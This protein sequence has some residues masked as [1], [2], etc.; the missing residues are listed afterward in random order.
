M[1]VSND[2]SLKMDIFMSKS[3]VYVIQFVRNTF[4]LIAGTSQGTVEGIEYKD[5]GQG[6]IST[7]GVD[8]DVLQ[9]VLA[10]APM[11]GSSI[12]YTSHQ[13]TSDGRITTFDRTTYR[14]VGSAITGENAAWMVNPTFDQDNYIYF[15]THALGM[16][17]LSTATNTVSTSVTLSHGSQSSFMVEIVGMSWVLVST[18]DVKFVA[19]DSSLTEVWTKDLTSLLGTSMTRFSCHDGTVFCSFVSD[20]SSVRPNILKITDWCHESCSEQCDNLPVSGNNNCISCASGY[21]LTSTGSCEKD[22]TTTTG[23]YV[24]SDYT[25]CINCP[26]CCSDCGFA[27]TPTAPYV[28]KKADLQCKVTVHSDYTFSSGVCS[29]KNNWTINL[30]MNDDKTV[31]TIAF[32]KEPSSF[33]KAANILVVTSENSWTE[34]TE[35]TMTLSTTADPKI[36]TLFFEY[37]LSEYNET[38][39]ISVQNAISK[40][41]ATQTDEFTYPTQIVE[42]NTTLT[43]PP[44]SPSPSLPP[45]D[46]EE[47]EEEEKPVAETALGI[48]PEAVETISS[49]SGNVAEYGQFAILLFPSLTGFIAPL[50]I[51]KIVALCPVIFHKKFILV[52]KL[53]VKFEEKDLLAM[54]IDKTHLYTK[55]YEE[56]KKFYS[57]NK[58]FQFVSIYPRVRGFKILLRILANII[59]LFFASKVESNLREIKKI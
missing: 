41:G 17:K 2:P 16:K 35:Y 59:F 43:A 55:E 20:K 49:T 4:Y 53:F 3:T 31:A 46:E 7:F 42:F 51:L 13:S 36:Y 54:L 56:K 32:D 18:S 47:T 24:N 14:M 23:K 52:L 25:S 5:T 6:S 22:C 15:V 27:T 1:N 29:L 11:S 19:F 26:L 45:S 8:L 28:P 33:T 50:N 12:V 44:P 38:I 21:N 58:E 37:S 30:S 57:K 40:V 39:T 48:S 10:F 34:G 9:P